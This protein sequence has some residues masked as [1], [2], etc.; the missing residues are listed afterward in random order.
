MLNCL[1]TGA[2][3]GIGAAISQGLLAAG[4][5]VIPVSRRSDSVIDF[6]DPD[7]EEKL[8]V[9]QR[10][11]PEIDIIILSAGYGQFVNLESFSWEAMQAMMQ[12]NFLAQALLVKTFLPAMK[13]R[14]GGKIIGIASECALQGQRLGSLYCASKFALR[15][16]LQSVR[17]ECSRADIAVSVVNPGFVNTPFFDNLDF[18][19]GAEQQHV[20]QP[21]QVAEMVLQIIN[22]NNNCVVEEVTI[23]PMQRVIQK[24]VPG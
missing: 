3:S 16:F 15:G 1:V 17:Q 9:L 22:T 12:V 18:Q 5:R 8:K 19:P 6:T 4:H 11:N 13:R 24:S 14:G 10:D 7:V 20:I 2:S 23:Q 21:E